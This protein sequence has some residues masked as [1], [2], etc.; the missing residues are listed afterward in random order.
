MRMRWMG[1]GVVLFGLAAL[2]ACRSLPYQPYVSETTVVATVG[3]HT[4]RL[5]FYDELEPHGRWVQVAGPGWVWRPGNV[6][7]D[8]RPYQLGRWVLTD[9]G[10]T[11]ASDEEFGWAVYHYGRWHSDVKYGWVWVPGSEWGP[12]WVAWHE[13]KGWV[14]WT[15]LPWQVSWRSGKGLNWGGISI[16]IEPD[17][18]SFVRTRHLVSPGIR[19]YVAPVASNTTLIQITNNVTNYIY[20][21]QRIVNKSVKIK[22]VGRAVGHGIP[23]YRVAPAGSPE[24]AR[25]NRV[26]GEKLLLYRPN[27]RKGRTTKGGLP[28]Q[29]HV[30]SNR[31]KPARHQKEHSRKT[32]PSAEPGESKQ[33]P[34]VHTPDD[35]RSKTRQYRK[36]TRNPGSPA[37][38]ERKDPAQSATPAQPATPA[39][40][41]RPTKSAKPTQSAKPAQSATPA[42]SARPTK[43]SKPAQ[44]AKP[45]PEKKK[46]SKS[47]KSSKDTDKDDDESDDEDSDSKKSKSKKSKSSK[48]SSKSKSEK[49]ESD[50]SDDDEDS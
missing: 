3:G 31:E 14:G 23:R 22:G 6:S 7:A 8:W 39:Q 49:S 32:R 47:K 45:T 16:T 5:V 4:G 38:D 40:S 44:S 46:S 15:P 29:S 18:W 19:Q 12:A 13:G 42:Q 36:S 24:E 28:A 10:W 35:S 41:A 2:T 1:I 37:S 21:D 30:D 48:K 33:V 20:V 17:R 34:A 9:H 50:D 11:W 27:V 25:G 26:K 43:S